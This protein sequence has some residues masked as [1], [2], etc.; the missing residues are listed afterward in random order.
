MKVILILSL[1]LLLSVSV[2]ARGYS[3]TNHPQ[4]NL[5]CPEANYFSIDN[6]NQTLCLPC[7]HRD[8]SVYGTYI[9]NVWNDDAC[10]KV[11]IGGY[12]DYLFFFL[13]ICA[14]II[15]VFYVTISSAYN[16]TSRMRFTYDFSSLVFFCLYIW[17]CICV[18]QK[19][20]AIASNYSAIMFQ[21]SNISVF[22]VMMIIICIQYFLA[23]YSIANNVPI[24]QKFLYVRIVLMIETIIFLI[25][26]LILFT[27]AKSEIPLLDENGRE[28]DTVKL[29]SKYRNSVT[30]IGSL[31]ISFL[32]MI[33]LIFYLS[34]HAYDMNIANPEPIYNPHE[35]FILS[36]P[37]QQSY[38]NA[39]ITV[40]SSGI[41]GAYREDNCV[42]CLHGQ[43]DVTFLPCKHQIVCSVNE[44]YKPLQTCPK[45]RAP[46][47]SCL[48]ISPPT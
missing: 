7:D 3:T 9:D 40:N 39:L 17:W 44:C 21:F 41:K 31:V 10:I 28:I 26:L 29:A 25:F 11:E 43:P 36:P 8:N 4:T 32:R 13:P 27:L 5:T 35:G 33:Y 48:M 38:Q 16:E 37:Q 12:G 6:F 20:I 14:L 15:G 23:K 22:V 46:I 47:S 18:L 2:T 42:V 45:C 34:R 19:P 24:N 30:Y 1:L